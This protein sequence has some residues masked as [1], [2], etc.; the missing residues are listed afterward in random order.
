MSIGGIPD[1]ATS[2]SSEP[3]GC[4]YRGSPKE[5]VLGNPKL[6]L[7]GKVV[8]GVGVVIPGCGVTTPPP[9]FVTVPLAVRPLVAPN[10]LV[11]VLDPR[12]T[13]PAAEPLLAPLPLP[14][15]PTAAAPPAPTP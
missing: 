3:K 1:A 7:L 4:G 8:L 11:M 13:V 6:E 9:I 12:P 15:P 5:F 10:A 14:V 2:P